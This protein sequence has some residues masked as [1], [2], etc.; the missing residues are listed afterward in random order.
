MPMICD[1]AKTGISSQP[2]VQCFFCQIFGGVVKE[3]RQGLYFKQR[4]GFGNLLFRYVLPKPKTG[5][6]LCLA[7]VNNLGFSV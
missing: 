1:P 4:L 3:E 2:L 5:A 7:S 6:N